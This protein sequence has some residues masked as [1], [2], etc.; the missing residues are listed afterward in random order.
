MAT[1]EALLN[2]AETR[3]TERFATLES[4]IETLNTLLAKKE[5]VEQ[6][7]FDALSDAYER[8]KPRE[9][10]RIFA[11]LEDDILVPVAAGMRTQAIA[12]VLAEMN[13]DKARRL[14]RLLAQ[15]GVDAG[16]DQP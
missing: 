6:A 4:E 1:R 13:P 9:A 14:T 12:G 7:E 5:K 11:V 10:A 15:N 8:M 2:A 16:A 3:L